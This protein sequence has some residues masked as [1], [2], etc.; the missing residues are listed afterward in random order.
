MRRTMNHNSQK[1]PKLPP[2]VVSKATSRQ[3]IEGNQA[4]KSLVSS[5]LLLDKDLNRF[6]LELLGKT[7]EMN[8][9]LEYKDDNVL[10]S[11][12]LGDA[13][14]TPYSR[15]LMLSRRH[16]INNRFTTKNKKENKVFDAE[17]KNRLLQAQKE[18][19]QK[20]KNKIKLISNQIQS[21]LDNFERKHRVELD[22]LETLNLYFCKACKKIVFLDRFRATTC[23]CNNKLSNPSDCQTADIHK[24]GGDVI[25]FIENNVW[26]EFGMDYLLKKQGFETQCGVNILGH[27][28]IV[29]EIDNY[30]EQKANKLRVFGECKNTDI[31][32]GN[33]LVFAGKMQ[34]IGCY[35]GFIFTTAL[36]TSKDV[37]H[38]ARS[39]HIGIIEQV[40]EKKNIDIIKE[41]DKSY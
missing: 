24:F 11:R 2:L 27:S 18:L 28:G 29:H 31:S 4:V 15:Y 33:V 13:R 21:G 10:L 9:L 7:K 12:I 17:I 32:V 3:A 22:I 23:E 41:M 39:K 34:D 5:R 20:L 19:N 37:I 35:K 14:P 40:L 38:L 1:T 36:G 26:L 16:L 25:K 6:L 8:R 30:A